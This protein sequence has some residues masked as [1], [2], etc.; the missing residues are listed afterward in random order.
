MKSVRNNLLKYD[1]FFND[2]KKASMKY[3]EA[4][5]ESDK[6][7]P[8]RMAPKLTNIHIHPNNFQK[9][10]VK[11]ATQVFSESVAIGLLTYACFNTLPAEGS[12]TSEFLEQFDKLFD[13]FN[14]SKHKGAK[15][16]NLALMG[17][18]VQIQFLNKMTDLLNSIKIF[19]S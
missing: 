8:L 1:I 15:K 2:N 17:A 4:F 5:Y 12:E 13:L 19:D 3:I 18:D 10:R 6:S 14:S 16:Y 11:Y 7:K 9:M